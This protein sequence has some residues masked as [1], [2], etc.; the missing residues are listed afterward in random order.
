MPYWLV[1]N[2]DINWVRT[3]VSNWTTCIQ[4]WYL[5]STFSCRACVC[6]YAALCVI[7]QRFTW[8]KPCWKVC[9]YP[10][11][12]IEFQIYRT[13]TAPLVISGIKAVRSRPS[14]LKL[15]YGI[16]M[17]NWL[18]YRLSVDVWGRQLLHVM[19]NCEP[20]RNKLLIICVNPACPTHVHQNKILRITNP[21]RLSLV[22][23]RGRLPKW[24]SRVTLAQT[25]AGTDKILT[26]LQAFP[27]Y[28]HD[29]TF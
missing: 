18:I 17:N 4:T 10:G 9:A 26:K 20:S 15:R 11:K 12:L 7:T 23:K 5:R 24:N 19:N 14:E 1:F 13:Y 2:C 25:G 29:K 8:C 16:N 21:K 22:D 6:H 28:F 3:V 27:H